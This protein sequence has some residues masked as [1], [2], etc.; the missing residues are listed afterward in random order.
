MQLRQPPRG[1]FS[2]GHGSVL[3]AR[4]PP[5]DAASAADPGGPPIEKSC[6][7]EPQ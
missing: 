3:L 2:R 7:M 4:K 5:D 1:A 6:L